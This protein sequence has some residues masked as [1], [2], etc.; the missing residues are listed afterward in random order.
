VQKLI[1]EGIVDPK[2]MIMIGLS[3]GGAVTNYVSTHSKMFAAAITYEGLDYL[4]DWG[5][6]PEY[7]DHNVSIEWEM[8]GT[9]FD[10]LTNYEA[11]SVMSGLRTASTPMMLVNGE[12]GINSG[13]STLV[14]NSLRLRGVDAQFIYYEGEGHGIQQ[15][16]NQADYLSRIMAWFGK[17]APVER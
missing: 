17:Y 6:R 8:G 12:H 13:A 7:A 1:A 2:R 4:V 10:K 16:V 5:G 11:N 15:H 9:P 3:Y 14:Y